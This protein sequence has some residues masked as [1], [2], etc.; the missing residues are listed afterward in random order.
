MRRRARRAAVPR[1]L[2]VCAS[3]KR[4]A[5]RAGNQPPT[6][7]ASMPSSAV[8]RSRR[9]CSIAAAARRRRNSR[10]PGHRPA[11]AAPARPARCRARGRRAAHQAEHHRFGQHQ[12]QPLARGEAQHAEQRE[13][14]R[15]PRDAERQHRKHQEGAGEQR[16]QRQHREVDAV[17][18]REV[19]PRCARV[20]RFGRAMP[21]GKRSAR[22]SRSVVTPARRR[23]SMRES[24]PALPIERSCAAP[25]SI[26]ASG[27]AAG[28]DGA[29]DLHVRAAAGRFAAERARRA[30]RQSRGGGLRNTVPGARIASRSAPP[31]GPASARA[32]PRDTTSASTPTTRTGMRSPSVAAQGCRSPAPGWRPRPVR[33]R[34]PRVEVFVEAALDGAQ[35]QVGLTT[36]GADRRGRTRS[37][38]TH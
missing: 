12:P 17:G 18:A 5:A 15:A 8:A 19:D 28:A 34:R 29:G 22:R 21:A 20:A 3:G 13:L 36:D 26:T 10:R 27:G 38:P 4:W 33:G 30:A 11:S 32:P 25:M 14:L 24:W 1:P 2:S 9:P 35:F 16:H 6:T 37:A 7:A 31:A 23:T